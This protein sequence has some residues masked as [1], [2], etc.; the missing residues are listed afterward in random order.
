MG[1]IRARKDTGA[2]F[3]DFRVNSQRCREQ[4]AL[5]DN[6]SNRKRLEKLLA[7]IEE[8]IALGVFD[9]AR[10]FPQSAYFGPP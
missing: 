4:T 6:T 5:L 9:Y 8:D 3:I 2:L 1:S 7:K 10:Y